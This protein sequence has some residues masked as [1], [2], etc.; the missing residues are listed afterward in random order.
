[1]RVQEIRVKNNA[2][3]HNGP[4][5]P[6][7]D[8]P[9]TVPTFD[10]FWAIW[11]KR[12]AKKDALRAWA[13][14]RPDQQTAAIKA[15]PAHVQRWRSEGRA[16]NHIPHPATWLNGERWEDELGEIFPQQSRAQP[17]RTAT[18]DRWWE[19]H[20]GMAR[21]AQ[22]VGVAPAWPGESDG[23]FC[24]RIRQAMDDIAR[25]GADGRMH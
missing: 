12:E 1:M 11:P 16:R 2:T 3:G 4:H 15:L 5:L 20:T 8:A 6:G 23:A 25:F 17:Q 22:E 18:A 24:A 7:V 19:S 21:K 14:L 13:K 10:T 9:E